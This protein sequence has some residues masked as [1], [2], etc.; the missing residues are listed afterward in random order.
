MQRFGL[1]CGYSL[2]QCSKL[3]GLF[4]FASGLHAVPVAEAALFSGH[5]VAVCAVCSFVAGDFLCAAGG[6]ADGWLFFGGVS[7]VGLSDCGVEFV[8]GGF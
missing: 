6:V 4:G 2:F 8:D 7:D 3:C 1:T 5:A